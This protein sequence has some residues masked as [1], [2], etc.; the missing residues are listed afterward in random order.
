[1]AKK[2]ITGVDVKGKRVLIRVDFNVPMDGGTITDDRRIRAALPTI[3]SVVGRGGRAILLSHLGR[4]KGNGYE[5]AHSLR[6]AAERLSELLGKPVAFPSRDCTDEAAAAAVEGM[7]DGDVL[8]LEN[9]RFHVEEKAGGMAFAIRLAS[10]GDVY[11]NDAFGTSHRADASM[12]AL[13]RA[14]PEGAPRVSGLLVEREIRYL[15]ETIASPARPFVEIF[16]GAKVSDKLDSLL[17]MLDKADDVLIG[18][19]MAYTL[20]AAA[21]KKVGDSRVELDHL[22]DAKKIID[23]AARERVEL[24]LPFDHICSTEFAEKAGDIEVIEDNIPAGFMGLDIGPKTQL[25]FSSIITK[26]RTIVWNGPMGV[27]EWA[28]FRV[29]TRH[30]AEAVA[31]ATAGGATSIVGGGDSAAAVESFG[32]A[33]EMSH[34]STGG[35]ASLEMLSGKPLPGVEVLDNA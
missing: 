22:A 29:G 17:H 1:M 7:R 23:T 18:G 10:Y 31:E 16:G 35:G 25:R 13:P 28:P 2:N 3:E 20:L 12:V 14:M 19:A 21:G 6:A 4:P 32:L 26:A 24:H 9:L 27:F 11:V 5:A 8:M 34:V 33:D 15:S 30:I